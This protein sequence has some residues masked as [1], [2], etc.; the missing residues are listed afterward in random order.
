MTDAAAALMDVGAKADRAGTARRPTVIKE[1]DAAAMDAGIRHVEE[2]TSVTHQDHLHHLPRLAKAEV[3]ALVAEDFLKVSG[4][5]RTTTKLVLANPR[6]RKIPR[7]S[8]STPPWPHLSL[9]S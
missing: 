6:L 7:R 8:T 5:E 3:E 1:R 4:R 2:I 9:R